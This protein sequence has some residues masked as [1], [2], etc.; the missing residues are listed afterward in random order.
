MYHLVNLGALWYDVLCVGAEI[1]EIHVPG[2]YHY[3]NRI[4]GFAKSV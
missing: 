3:G 4:V 2:D 1:W